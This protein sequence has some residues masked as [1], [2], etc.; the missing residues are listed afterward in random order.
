MLYVLLFCHRKE[1]K[2]FL[3]RYGKVFC[4]MKEFRYQQWPAKKVLYW[5]IENI[6]LISWPLT[7]R[8]LEPLSDKFLIKTTVYDK[9]MTRQWKELGQTFG[10]WKDCVLDN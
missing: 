9:I 4:Y 8:C 5:K 7:R 3:A 2:Y 6:C 10:L 1:E